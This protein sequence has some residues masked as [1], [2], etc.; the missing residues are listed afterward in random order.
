MPAGRVLW[1][2][3]GGWDLGFCITTI[4]FARRWESYVLNRVNKA[5]LR[6]PYVIIIWHVI[7]SR[8]PAAGSGKPAA[9]TRK[10]K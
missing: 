6:S 5:L 10:S 2:R 1:A 4:R 8:F 3:F 9:N 7:P